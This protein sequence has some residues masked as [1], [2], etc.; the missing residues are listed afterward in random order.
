MIGAL[1]AENPARRDPKRTLLRIVR[2]FRDATAAPM[3]PAGADRP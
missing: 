2:A 1:V 3:T